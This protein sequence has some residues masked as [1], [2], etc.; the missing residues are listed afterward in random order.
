MTRDTADP[1][2]TIKSSISLPLMPA[3]PAK[4]S[5]WHVSPPVARTIPSLFESL[6][7]VFDSIIMLLCGS[8]CLPILVF[9]KRLGGYCLL[10]KFPVCVGIGNFER[11]F[12][13]LCPSFYKCNR[14]TVYAVAAHWVQSNHCC[15]MQQLML[16]FHL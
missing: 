8:L 9:L 3:L 15:T 16:M 6:L 11:H 12:T 7:V 5:V 10:T 1:V 4:I 13:E 2:F 14:F